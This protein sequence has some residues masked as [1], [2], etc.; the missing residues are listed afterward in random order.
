LQDEQDE[1]KRYN[2]EKGWEPFN[3]HD[4]RRIA[5]TALLMSGRCAKETSLM[6]GTIREA[7][8]RHYGKLDAIETA[9]RS[10]KKRPEME[11]S[12][13]PDATTIARA[14]TGLL[15]NAGIQR[16]LR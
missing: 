6:V 1:L 12:T 9:W 4:Y 7:I 5:F 10:T 2:V 16:K 15:T 14:K 8:R 11:T 3:L 13:N